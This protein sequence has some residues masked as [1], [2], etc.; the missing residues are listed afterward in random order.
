MMG[1]DAQAKGDRHDM[2]VEAMATEARNPLESHFLLRSLDPAER[3][4]IMGYARNRRFATGE[5]IFLKG[6]AGTG[7]MAVIAGQ[8][9]IS[10]PSR[11]GK[12]IVLNVIRPGEV[13]GEIAL[14][15]GG[16]R[17]ADATAL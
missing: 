17:T 12:E 7:M 9:R 2:H 15:D 6:S 14:L 8:V 11:E 10:A 3:R 4:G 5:T 1:E 13:F 16:E